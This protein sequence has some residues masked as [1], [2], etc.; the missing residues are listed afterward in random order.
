MPHCCSEFRCLPARVFG[1]PKRPNPLLRQQSSSHRANEAAGF[2]R[3]SPCLDHRHR[4][5]QG[6]QFGT[7]L[8]LHRCCWPLP[9]WY[10][11]VIGTAVG[12][13]LFHHPFGWMCS[14]SMPRGEAHLCCC[15]PARPRAI[16]CGWC[17]VL[18]EENQLGWRHSNPIFH[19]RN[20]RYLLRG[21]RE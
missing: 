2:W 19:F 16:R 12:C 5:L 8:H 18:L 7:A 17:R 11:P 4:V 15:W 13:W 6:P 1:P 14:W 21:G 20:Y 3:G 10:I 9:W